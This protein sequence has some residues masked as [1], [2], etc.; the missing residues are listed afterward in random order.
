MP[1]EKF[2][3]IVI[4]CN[5]VLEI[6]YKS[7]ATRRIKNQSHTMS[8][9]KVM[10]EK[11]KSVRTYWKTVGFSLGNSN[12]AFRCF[13][14]QLRVFGDHWYLQMPLENFLGVVTL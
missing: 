5:G 11:V 7:R 2:L 9:S 10:G 13:L 4:V 14:E 6:F 1:L 8:Q 3:G 12:G